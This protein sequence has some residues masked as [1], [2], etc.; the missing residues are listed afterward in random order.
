MKTEQTDELNLAIADEYMGLLNDRTIV[1][2]KYMITFSGVPGSGKTTLARRLASDLKAQYVHHDTMREIIAKHGYNVVGLAIAPISKIVVNRILHGDNNK[3]LILD[4][5]LDRTWQMYFDHVTQEKITPLIIRLDV[6]RDIV[7]A[8]L[9]AR[10]G[11][12][13]PLVK[14]FEAY[15][16]EY[17]NCKAKV[18]A[19]MTLGESYDYDRVLAEIKSIIFA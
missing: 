16:S 15:V 5:S 17:E 8:R 1:N 18:P 7:F 10:D 19:T 9:V 4:S 6:P 12:D 13:S 2:P 14:R 3:L 11:L